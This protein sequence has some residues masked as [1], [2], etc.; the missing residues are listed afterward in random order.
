MNEF[1]RHVIGTE[2]WDLADW[3]ANKTVVTELVD[4]DEGVPPGVNF[5]AMAGVG[6]RKS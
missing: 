4:S 1:R 2:Q 3:K 5:S 6:I